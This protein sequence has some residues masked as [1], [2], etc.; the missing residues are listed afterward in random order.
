[1]TDT[2]AAHVEGTHTG[3]HSEQG[4]RRAN[5]RAGPAIR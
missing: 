3:L 4:A 5:T 1:M 2:K